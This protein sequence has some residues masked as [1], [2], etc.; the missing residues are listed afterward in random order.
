M[1]RAG[2]SDAEAEKI[3]ADAR[4]VADAGAFCIVVE[5]VMED[6]ADRGDRGGRGAGDRHRRLGATATGRCW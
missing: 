2:K 5:G 3:L 4:A 6:I 1:A